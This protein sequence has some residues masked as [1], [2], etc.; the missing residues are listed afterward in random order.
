M[1]IHELQEA[2]DKLRSVEGGIV[3]LREKH[4]ACSH[5]ERITREAYDALYFVIGELDKEIM[6]AHNK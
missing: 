4:R 1:N 3:E 5:T 6:C 2:K